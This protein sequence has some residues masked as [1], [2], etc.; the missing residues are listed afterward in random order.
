[1]GIFSAQRKKVEESIT[2]QNVHMEQKHAPTIEKMKR[3]LYYQLMII[4]NYQKAISKEL[5]PLVE[6]VRL[7]I[8]NITFKEDLCKIYEVVFGQLSQLYNLSKELY[9]MFQETKAG[10]LFQVG[11]VAT[12]QQ[13]ATEKPLPFGVPAFGSTNY[14]NGLAPEDFPTGVKQNVCVH[15]HEGPGICSPKLDISKTNT[16]RVVGAFCEDIISESELQKLQK[17]E[18]SLRHS[19]DCSPFLNSQFSEVDQPP[20][21]IESSNLCNELIVE[22]VADILTTE[23]SSCTSLHSKREGPH[24]LSNKSKSLN[25]NQTYIVRSEWE[26]WDTFEFP[27]SDSDTNCW[28]SPEKEKTCNGKV[29]IS[30]LDAISPQEPL[31]PHDIFCLPNAIEQVAT[32]RNCVVSPE[33]YESS[34]C[35]LE[36]L[37]RS[38]FS[39]SP[40]GRAMEPPV[41]SEISEFQFC[42]WQ[43]ME[44]RVS[45]AIDPHCFYIQHVGKDLPELMRKFNIECSR[46]SAT[47]SSIPMINSY[48]CAWLPENKQ[49]YRSRVIRIVG[50]VA[51]HGD[52]QHLLLEVLC[53]DYGFSACLSLS[54]LKPL[55][56]AYCVLPQQALCVSLANVSPMHGVT[57]SRSEINWFKKSVKNKTFFARL[58]QKANIMTV[59]LFS[60][61]GKI[62][63]M[64]R[65]SKLS[66]RMVAAGLARYSEGNCA[67]PKTGASIP[68]YWKQRLVQLLSQPTNLRK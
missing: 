32:S 67:S 47:L 23:N 1:M 33:Q 34:N 3:Y 39:N 57:W 5:R 49:W 35:M 25:V 15:I 16:S 27:T 52:H 64:R 59:A 19:S 21:E 61:R 44:I 12:G 56:P 13:T 50:D 29:L 42:R 6:W 22:T 63:I 8:Q 14:V 38:H 58:Y 60:E 48:V 10:I 41:A 18:Q 4:E 20:E 62:G 55:P 45:Y 65:G 31:N 66:Q 28:V 7:N 43:E 51:T 17:K 11:I 30:T 9:K 40:F 36:P 2:K 53:V 68:L 24:I 26:V 54:Y 37:N 46:N